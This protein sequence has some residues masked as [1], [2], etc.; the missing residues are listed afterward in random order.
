MEQANLMASRIPPPPNTAFAATSRRTKRQRA[1]STGYL[2]FIRSL[3]SVL[4]G[5]GPVQAA[6]VNYADIRYGK[7]GRGKSQKDDD[8]WAL[9]LC[10][11]MHD[12]QHRAGNESAWWINNGIP[13][14]VRVAISLWRCWMIGDTETALT[15]IDHAHEP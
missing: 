5:A 11:E 12:L 9:P 6:H 13:D 2:D 14:P 4:P 3:P 1:D 8:C 7:L 10:A 15:I